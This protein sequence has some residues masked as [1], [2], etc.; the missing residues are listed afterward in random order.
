MTGQKYRVH[1]VGVERALACLNN[2]F[3]A[4]L[5]RLSVSLVNVYVHSRHGN[6]S[7]LMSSDKA[8]VITQAFSSYFGLMAYLG[9][10][11]PYGERIK[12]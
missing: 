12:R 1:R 2:F 4:D 6:G 10:L 9:T 11:C 3:T 7:W 8:A 5:P